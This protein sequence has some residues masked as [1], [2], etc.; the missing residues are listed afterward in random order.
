MN[1][2]VAGLYN[3][4]ELRL[5]VAE[6]DITLPP[7]INTRPSRSRVAAWKR[8]DVVIVPV[9]EKW[10]TGDGAA[11]GLV[12]GAAVG[13]AV[14]ALAEGVVE[15]V[16]V[17]VAVGVRV[18]L[19]AA[20]GVATGVADGDSEGDGVTS[21][22]PP[23]AN[24]R[25][26]HANPRPTASGIGRRL[27]FERG[28]DRADSRPIQWVLPIWH[29]FPRSVSPLREIEPKAD[30]PEH[31]SVSSGPSRPDGAPKGAWGPAHQRVARHSATTLTPKE[32]IDIRTEQLP[33]PVSS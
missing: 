16:T 17:G 1:L 7:T 14:D 13:L 8:R 6:R 3:S 2:P 24:A 18:A 12:G 30:A 31:A 28:R 29:P 25:R 4:A 19:V 26:P 23:M 15:G 5:A 27:P 22:Q 11:V 9:T 10:P 20:E 21:P 33:G 32:M